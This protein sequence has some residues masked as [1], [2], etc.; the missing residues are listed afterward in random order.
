M[1]LKVKNSPDSEL[2]KNMTR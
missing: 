1:T 2:S